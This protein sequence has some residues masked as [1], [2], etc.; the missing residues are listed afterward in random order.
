MEVSRRHNTPYQKHY[1]GFSENFLY[2]FPRENIENE[3]LRGGP[4]I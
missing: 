2:F 1:K 4:S 3:Y